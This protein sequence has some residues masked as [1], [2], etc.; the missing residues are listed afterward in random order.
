[1]NNNDQV[2]YKDR[3]ASPAIPQRSDMFN[4][5]AITHTPAA[6]FEVAE[7]GP[8][9]QVSVGFITAMRV[10]MPAKSSYAVGL[11][12]APSPRMRV[13]GISNYAGLG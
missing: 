8:S 6:G 1:M 7:Y 2:A 4:D 3:A 13:T 11:S 9:Y 5:N 10:M 12:R